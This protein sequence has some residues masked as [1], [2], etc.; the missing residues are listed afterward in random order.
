VAASSPPPSPPVWAAKNLGMVASGGLCSLCR[1][2]QS[3]LEPWKEKEQA[4]PIQL[5]HCRAVQGLFSA[6]RSAKCSAAG[7][8]VTEGAMKLAI[9]ILVFST[10]LIA[11]ASMVSA[12]AAAGQPACFPFPVYDLNSCQAACDCGYNACRRQERRGSHRCSDLRK[13]C[14]QRC[15]DTYLNPDIPGGGPV[16]HPDPC[17]GPFRLFCP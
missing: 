9:A 4:A 3:K 11:D 7:L 14:G 16:A 1:L 8:A 12:R 17:P 6:R 2:A 15:R 5:I 13:K 10:C